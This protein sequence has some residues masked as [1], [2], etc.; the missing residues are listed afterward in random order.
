MEIILVKTV[1]VLQHGRMDKSNISI[2]SFDQDWAS[3]EICLSIA[4]LLISKNIKSTWFITNKGFFLEKLMQFPDLFELGIHPNFLPD[5]SHGNSLMDVLDNITS[6]VPMARVSRGHAVF[7]YGSILQVM[8][9]K[10]NISWDLTMFMY[11]KDNLY[12]TK[13]FT[14]P[15]NFLYRLP[16]F[17]CD[18]HEFN[19]PEKDWSLKKYQSV[20]GVKV[21]SFHPIHVY[22]NSGTAADYINY[23]NNNSNEELKS[24][25][26]PLIGCRNAFDDLLD[27]LSYQQNYFISQL[28]N[29]K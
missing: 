2:L 11:E 6:I 20:F 27:V 29:E 16:V 4:D 17:W 13:L 28:K 14:S 1:S 23:K 18:D 8:R 7:Q 25:I 9:N 24:F 19:N 10:Y 21:F 3:D 26:N 5:S 15:E 12:P 22:L